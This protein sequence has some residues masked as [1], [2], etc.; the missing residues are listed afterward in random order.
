MKTKQ[1]LELQQQRRPS[2]KD[3]EDDQDTKDDVDNKLELLKYATKVQSRGLK[4][5]ISPDFVMAKFNQQKDK[6]GVVEITNDAYFCK[7]TINMLTRSKIWKWI[8]EEKT[9]KQYPLTD[10]QKAE[11]NYITEK[12]FDTFMTRT[13]MTA[14][15]NRNVKDNHILRL[16]A[17][18]DTEEKEEGQTTETEEETETRLQKVIDKFK[19]KKEIEQ[20]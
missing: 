12:M 13:G 19:G 1:D 3:E 11:I 4:K 8:K 17:G 15:L 16:I 10:T 5:D 2:Y 14:V 7:R 18:L 6:E 9:W 20:E